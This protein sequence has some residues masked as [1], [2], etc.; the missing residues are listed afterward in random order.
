M[1][2]SE[3]VVGVE[4]GGAWMSCLVA[5]EEAGE[6][7]VLGCGRQ[8]CNG[9]H[10]G[11]LIDLEA[12]AEC[13]EAA[14]CAAED[15][16]HVHAQ[17]IFIGAASPHYRGRNSRGC[18]HVTREDRIITEDL[19]DRAVEAAEQVSLPN[20]REIVDAVPQTFTLDEMRWVA[21]PVGMTGS[22]LEAEV[23]LATDA[24]CYLENIATAVDKTHCDAEGIVFKPL[25][26]A[27]AVLTEDE[28]RLGC[29]AI[30]IGGATMNI[31]LFRDGSPRFSSVLPIGGRHI[32]ND[33]AVCLNIPTE[34]AEEIKTAHACASRS[35]LTRDTRRRAIEI[36][37]SGGRSQTVPRGRLCAIVEC[38]VEEMLSIARTELSRAG[39]GESYQGGVVL[40]GGTARM[41]GI[42]DV[43]RRVFGCPAR[44]GRPRVKSRM[45]DELED[46]AW[47][48]CVGVL[49]CGLEQRRRN[50]A[51]GPQA[52]NP[53][54]RLISK[55]LGWA[56]AAF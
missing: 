17:T 3:Y 5:A 29:L 25:A 50:I 53:I 47:A 33:I 56:R 51:Q 21:N 10:R 2:Q 37:T 52:S 35:K 4:I 20:E 8:A 48:A 15:S 45:G 46:P 13:I 22:R 49:Q 23:H 40:V 7:N 38:R 28:K 11:E 42:A 31:I 55:S 14:I 16:G 43:A 12:A 36:N 26:S 44:I 54:S 19:R 18:V 27:R 34:Q 32:T 30:D 6:L 41:Q 1:E 24:A 39:F 9:F